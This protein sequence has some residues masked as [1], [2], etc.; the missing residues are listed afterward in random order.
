[1][2]Y[3]KAVALSLV[4]CAWPAPGRGQDVEPGS[5]YVL[6]GP[7]FMAIRVADADRAARWY[8][9]T[10]GLEEV[11]RV[12]AE[13]ERYRIRILSGHGLGVELIQERGAE[14]ASTVG[15]GHFKAGMYVVDLDAFHR[16]LRGIGVDVDPEIFVDTAL[17]A[18][19][20]VFRDL[21]GNRIQAFQR[22]DGAC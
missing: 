17:A 12:D 4:L 7:A 20:F 10:L 11:N 5:P 1:M 13:D 8:A 21:E 15:L 6:A 19:S 16:F 18:R 9:T 2:G 14:P 22:C 3:G